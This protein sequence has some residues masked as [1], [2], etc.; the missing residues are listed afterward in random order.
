[1]MGHWSD[2]SIVVWVYCVMGLLCDGSLQGKEQ[3]AARKK[4]ETWQDVAEAG[5]AQF[6]QVPCRVFLWARYPC[7]AHIVFFYERGT[8]GRCR[9]RPCPVHTGPVL[10]EYSG[11][12]GYN[13]V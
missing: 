3:V 7:I 1:M 8:P 6:I 9:D 13:P 10:S 12:L 2:R 4:L 5:L 11:D